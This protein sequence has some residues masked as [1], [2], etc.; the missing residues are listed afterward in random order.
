[1][2]FSLLVILLFIAFFMSSKAIENYNAAMRPTES[3]NCT[4]RLEKMSETW[5][6][7]AIA[8]LFL[9]IS[10]LISFILA[11][12]RIETTMKSIIQ[13]PQEGSS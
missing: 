9:I 10:L 2:S 5:T 8:E 7:F 12:R 3:V 11:L 13:A 4:S 1:L 6:N